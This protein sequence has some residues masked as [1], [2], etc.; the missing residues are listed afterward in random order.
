MG[1]PAP[2]STETNRLFIDWSLVL[3]ASR[4]EAVT[5]ISPHATVRLEITLIDINYKSR[6][7]HNPITSDSLQDRRTTKLSIIFSPVSKHMSTTLSHGQQLWQGKKG[8]QIYTG[9]VQVSG[10]PF[11]CLTSR[12]KQLIA[13]DEHTI[14][15]P[16]LLSLTQ[17]LPVPW[18]TDKKTTNKSFSPWRPFYLTK[19]ANISQHC[20]PSQTRNLLPFLVT[21]HKEVFYSIQKK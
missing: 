13:L 8:R 20:L 12:S 14:N 2:G 11:F 15:S 10:Q 19:V 7:Y 1:V 18:N 5:M 21:G 3:I 4:D 17:G 16:P 6:L 9:H